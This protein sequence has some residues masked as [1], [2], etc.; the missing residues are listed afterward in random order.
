M[1][2]RF[3]RSLSTLAVMSV[4]ALTSAAYA[5][6]YSL[7]VDGVKGESTKQKEEIDI[8]SFSWGFSTPDA[9]SRP[10]ASRF[11]VHK[12]V[13]SSSPILLQHLL[14]G[15]VITSVTFI[16]RKSAGDKAQILV[17]VKLEDVRVVDVQV[18]GGEGA[19]ASEQVSF[20]F[21]KLSYKYFTQDKAG[22]AGS[23][24]EAKWDA[25]AQKR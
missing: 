4:L 16:T 8:S 2:K 20:T 6:D 11:T 21:S 19:R 22:K 24:A 9:K 10:T 23:S 13:D 12:F 18:A 3:Q 25:V 1:Y 15:R 5:D 17:E 14:D 7:K